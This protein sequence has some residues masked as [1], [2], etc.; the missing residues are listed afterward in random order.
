MSKKLSD[1]LLITDMDGTLLDD[2]KRL[3][4][5]NANA[6][7][8]F[9]E[10]GGKFA[11]ATGRSIFA[12]RRFIDEIGVDAPC[13]LC[14]GA[15]VHDIAADK[16]IYVRELPDIARSYAQ[17]LMERFPRAGAELV[18]PR[19]VYAVRNNEYEAAHVKMCG[20]EAICMGL[21]EITDGGW[22]KFLFACDKEYLDE[23]MLYKAEKGMDEV[24]F[25]RSSDIFYEM[26]PFN[27]SKGTAMNEIRKLS[28]YKD[29]KFI[30]MGDF[31]NDSDMLRKADVGCAVANANAGAKESADIIL[32]S[33][34]NESAVAEVVELILGGK[35]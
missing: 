24:D 3:S 20:C 32:K 15:V 26:L 5:K 23:M 21:D 6:I 25:V 35:I 30:A 14:N 1:I 33:S 31:D 29:M 13:V 12:A 17:E 9:Q 19:H 22:L 4:E 7:H 10:L 8:H 11:I 34:C 18:K 28:E 2:S 27:I 16:P